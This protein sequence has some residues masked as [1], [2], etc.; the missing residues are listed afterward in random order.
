MK[1]IINIGLKWLY[2]NSDKSLLIEE[3]SI[4]DTG[5]GNVRAKK[6]VRI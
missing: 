4:I 3:E 6:V 1:S 2:N 5:E